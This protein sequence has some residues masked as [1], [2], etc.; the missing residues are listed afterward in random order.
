MT[1]METMGTID[2]IVNFG[3]LS[4]SLDSKGFLFSGNSKI[5]STL[6]SIVETARGEKELNNVFDAMIYSRELK[7]EDPESIQQFWDENVGTYTWNPSLDDW[8]EDLGGDKIIFKFPSSESTSAND[9]TITI[10]NYAGINIRNPI[11]D[12]IILV[13]FRFH[14]MLI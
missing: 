9:A 8:D 2:V 12:W 7:G 6:N 10:Y 5:F 14:L 3:D 11:H 4:A 13:I 1:R